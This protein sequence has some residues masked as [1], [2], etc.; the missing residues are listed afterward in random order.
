MYPSDAF[1]W[2]DAVHEPP[3]F[4][5]LLSRWKKE[6]KQGRKF[7]NLDIDK[8]LKSKSTSVYSNTMPDLGD[9]FWKHKSDSRPNLTIDNDAKLELIG[10]G[11]THKD[12]NVISKSNKLIDNKEKLNK[13]FGKFVPK[14]PELSKD[15]DK[16]WKC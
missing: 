10:P 5:F 8:T 9:G 16:P 6:K 3:D 4:K 11:K 15:F 14:Y 7:Y 13:L 2:E 1:D 12:V